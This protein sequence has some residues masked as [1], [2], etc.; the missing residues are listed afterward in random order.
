MLLCVFAFPI[1]AFRCVT[2]TLYMYNRYLSV[3]TLAKDNMTHSISIE[4]QLDGTVLQNWLKVFLTELL[5]TGVKKN[6]S[7]TF[8]P[9]IEK[10]LIVAQW[11]F[12]DG[13]LPY[14]LGLRVF[15]TF[16]ILCTLLGLVIYLDT[17]LIYANVDLGLVRPVTFICTVIRIVRLYYF[18][19]WIIVFSVVTGATD[20]IGKAFAKQVFITVWVCIIV[21]VR[22]M[23]DDGDI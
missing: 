15:T 21:I 4:R 5:A 3:T 17:R 1:W 7:I 23:N 8:S 19:L 22:V 16:A 13:L 14:L 9:S 20:G 11:R 2:V 12:L 10:W 18:K 6:Y